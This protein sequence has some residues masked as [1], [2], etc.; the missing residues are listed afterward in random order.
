MHIFIAVTVS[1]EK[2]HAAYFSDLEDGLL[3]SKIDIDDLEHDEVSIG[4]ES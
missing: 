3:L 1:P 4:I 2:A